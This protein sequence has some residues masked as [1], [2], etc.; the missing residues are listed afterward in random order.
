VRE[1]LLI[2]APDHVLLVE[3][4]PGLRLVL[5]QELSEVLPFK[6]E[7]IAPEALI[8]NQGHLIGA[9]VVS[10]PGRAKQ[11]V[12]LL[13]P[14]HPFLVLKPSEVDP[15]FDVVYKL[16]EP[17]VIGIVSISQEFLKSGR[18]LLTPV[19]GDQ[20]TIE[21]HLLDGQSVR[22]LSR[23][24]LVFCDSIARKTVRARRVMHYRFTSDTAAS[25]IASRIAAVD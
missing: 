16:K 13:P 23:F 11:V 19:V 7:A 21:E 20:H 9:L 12:S 14:G 15:H 18:A 17:S 4:E 6:L 22:N 24:D 25:D 10:L 1:R 3:D 5:H 2:Q 8:E